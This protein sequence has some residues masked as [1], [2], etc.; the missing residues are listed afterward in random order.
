[1]VVGVED[2]HLVR[3]ERVAVHR[4]AVQH[5]LVVGQGVGLDD[6]R[7]RQVQLGHHL[8]LDLEGE[9][10]AVGVYDAPGQQERSV[11]Q[12]GGRGGDV[13]EHLIY[14]QRVLSG[15]EGA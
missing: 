3:E 1:R 14:G 9:L 7:A 6:V 15:R 11:V 4:V 8:D 13:V 12:L 2:R 5:D 10:G